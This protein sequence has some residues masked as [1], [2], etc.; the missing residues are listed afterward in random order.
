MFI[1]NQGLRHAV[2]LLLTNGARAIPA[3][4][5][6]DDA[7]AALERLAQELAAL[8]HDMRAPAEASNWLI[9]EL[10]RAIDRMPNH[11]G[12]AEWLAAT[13][14]ARLQSGA[15]SERR[16]LF[17]IYVPEDRLPIAAPLAIE[18]TKR[19]VTVAFSEYEVSTS[20]E[21]EVAIARG[22]AGN[23]CGAVLRTR[24]FDRAGLGFAPLEPEQVRTLME[25]IAPVTAAGDL[26]DWIRNSRVSK[27]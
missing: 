14:L 27:R 1:P 21:L 7:R 11:P 16:D 26:I 25:P 4:A 18:L 13:M 9:A 23:T 2:T 22:L 12:G 20:Q 17:L 6:P 5:S 24:A 10:M 15:Q 8:A 19:R 3:N